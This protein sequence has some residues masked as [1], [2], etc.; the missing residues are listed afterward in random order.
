MHL[1]IYMFCIM[2]PKQLPYNPHSVYWIGASHPTQQPWITHSVYW[3]RASHPTQQPWDTHFVYWIGASHPIGWHISRT[4]LD[5]QYNN[6]KILLV[7]MI[8]QSVANY[9]IQCCSCNYS[10]RRKFQVE[11]CYCQIRI[12]YNKTLFW[13]VFTLLHATHEG[14]TKRRQRNWNNESEVMKWQTST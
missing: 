5:I 2:N 6:P 11:K 7:Y 10:W 12:K 9:C 14:E 1:L 13:T 4:E 3:I 8:I